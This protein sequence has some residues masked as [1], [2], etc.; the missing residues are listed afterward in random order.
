MKRTAVV[1]SLLVAL[2]ISAC[3]SSGVTTSSSTASAGDPATDHLAEIL[4]RGTLVLSTDPGYPPQSFAVKGAQ[5]LPTTKC[6]EN[7]MTGNQ[8]AGYDADVGKLLAKSLGVEPCFVV[9]TWTEITGGNWGDRWDIAY[10]SG[11][12]N[13]DRIP[14]L[15]M[16]TP[17]RAE[18]QRYFVRVSSPYHTPS[19]LNGKSIGVCNSCTVEFYLQGRLTIPQQKT[20]L[21]V[22]NAKIVTYESEPPGLL[23]ASK[24]KIDAYLSAA[25]EGEGAIRQGEDLR[26]LPGAAF[27][28]DD[29]GFLDKSSSRSQ[30]AFAQRVD[31]IIT[32]LIQDGQLKALSMKYFG[33]DYATPA[34]KFNLAALH[35]Q[36]P[37]RSN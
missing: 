18:P 29:T 15:W 9:P 32:Q 13:S 1:G 12:I 25:G 31:Q 24:G 37:G 8:I 30:K 2:A 7:Q 6:A 35:Q 21:D 27:A 26:A 10:G 5:R 23:A 19:Q 22:K 3:G 14:R 34:L 17:Y 33:E 11:A 20:A 16:T 4:A 28:M 36:I